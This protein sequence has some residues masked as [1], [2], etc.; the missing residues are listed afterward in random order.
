MNDRR[1]REFSY[2]ELTTLLHALGGMIGTA[3]LARPMY[4]EA[5]HEMHCQRHERAGLPEPPASAK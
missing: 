3:S 1:F 4:T 2:D 5:Y